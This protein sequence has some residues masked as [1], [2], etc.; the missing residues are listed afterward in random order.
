MQRRTD[1]VAAICSE[2]TMRSGYLQGA[3]LDTIYFGGGTPSLLTDS[4]LMLI[5]DTIDQNYNT[6][7]LRE[8]SLEANPDDL[9]PSYV[10]SLLRTPIQRLS[11]GIQS[12]AAAEL[13]L[14]NRA[15]SAQEAERAVKT[16][17]DAGLDNISADLI[18]GTPG[19]TEQVLRHNIDTLAG[20]QVPHI[21]AYGLTIEPRTALSAWVNKGKVV[22]MDDGQSAAQYASAMALL[23]AAGYEQYEIS[24]YA[25]DGRYAIHNTNYWRQRPYLGIGPSAHSYNGQSRQWNVRNNQQ[26]IQAI[27]TEGSIPCQ[28]EMLSEREKINELIMTRLRTMW[29]LDMVELGLKY[30]DASA[31]AVMKGALRYLQSGA[32]Q[33]DGQLLKLTKTGRLVADAVCVDLFV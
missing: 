29:G 9:S 17:Q 25:R 16:V 15:H 13:K 14:M 11:I 31:N 4:E 6:G 21:S 20:M 33:L 30:G 32:L 12:F 8:V 22:L 28:M 27:L 2:L 7:K 26:Y 19:S 1:M 24:N 18:F 10:R 5:F 23:P 3:A